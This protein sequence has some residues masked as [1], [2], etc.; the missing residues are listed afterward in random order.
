MAARPV[1]HQLHTDRSLQQGVRDGDRRRLL[2]L[3]PGL[4]AIARAI[5]AVVVV[6]VVRGTRV[7]VTVWSDLLAATFGGS[8]ATP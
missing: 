6:G 2:A 7:G 5:A 4:R 3:K 1:H 8:Q